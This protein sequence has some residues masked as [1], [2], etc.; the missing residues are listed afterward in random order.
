MM[1]IKKLFFVTNIV[2]FVS[3]SSLFF[4]AQTQSTIFQL[5]NSEVTSI[6]LPPVLLSPSNSATEVSI[7]PQLSWRS[8]TG[9]TSYQVQISTLSSFNSTIFNQSGISGTSISVNTSLSEGTIYYWRVKASNADG[10]G[11]WSSKWSFTTTINETRIPTL[12]FSGLRWNVSKGFSGPGPNNWFNGIKSVWI[13]SLGKLHLAIRKIGANWYCSSITAQDTMGY[14]EYSFS[15]SSDVE[16]YDPNIV[17]GLFIYENDTKEI[18]IE[19][20]RWGEITSNPG[21]YVVQPASSG[22]STSFS[23][24]L[25]GR[26]STHKFT[27]TKGNVKFQSF[28]SSGELIKEWTYKGSNMPVPNQMKPH[29]NFWLM[30]GLAPMNLSDAELIISNF[31]Y[32]PS[33]LLDVDSKENAKPAK[34]QLF[35]N[36]PNPFN[37]STVIS[38]RL[39]VISKVTLKVYD[40]LG[41]ELSTLVDEEQQPGSYNSQFSIQNSQLPSSIYFYRLQAGEFSQMKKMILLK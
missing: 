16:L 8:S 40:V 28:L 14:G 20:S 25:Q 3:G 1:S 34:F 32:I 5:K 19:F 9:A 37:P 30:S 35:Q 18:D 11:N 15:L 2:L 21:W 24:N 22:T 17:V 12:D 4:Y 38:Y 7:T 41:R 36:Y 23:L 26:S 6:P 31:K 27:W 29:I 33:I 13:D 39:S 10:S